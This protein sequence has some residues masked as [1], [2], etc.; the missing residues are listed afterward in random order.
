[1]MN[2]S[3]I[4]KNN[5]ERRKAIKQ[6][7]AAA[8]AKASEY[9]TLTAEI[10]SLRADM[11]SFVATTNTFMKDMQDLPKTVQTTREEMKATQKTAKEVQEDIKATGIM[12][13]KYINENANELNWNFII[14]A[15][16]I[17]G[18][19]SSIYFC[20]I[21]FAIQYHFAPSADYAKRIM[22][23]LQYSNNGENYIGIFDDEDKAKRK[24]ENQ[25]KY[26]DMENFK[27][28]HTPQQ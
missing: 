17:M 9:A 11:K 7:E 21:Q 12:A 28:K 3:D 8:N 16:A 5:Q 13:K 22:W 18:I 19:F 27:A 25:K 2:I 20:G 15:C 1:M 24:Y 10:K 14:K 4:T 6:A 26:E 23:N